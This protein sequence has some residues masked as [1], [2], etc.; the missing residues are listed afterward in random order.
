MK[1]IEFT[2]GIIISLL[3]FV[4]AVFAGTIERQVHY[5]LKE[6][7]AI[8]CDEYVASIKFQ[9]QSFA[10]IIEDTLSHKKTFVWNG[11]KKFSCD[12]ITCYYID[13]DS[14][15]KCIL[16]Y[17]QGKDHYLKVENK[18]YGPYEEINYPI[19]G[20]SEQ[21]PRNTWYL[22]HLFSKETMKTW[23]Y[24]N[25]FSYQ[26]MGHNFIYLDGIISSG[27]DIGEMRIDTLQATSGRTSQ[28]Y[29]FKSLNKT[30]AAKLTPTHISIDNVDYNLPLQPNDSVGR[31]E[32]YVFNDGSC[33][34]ELNVC[35]KRNLDESRELKVYISKGGMK[36][37][38]PDEAFNFKKQQIE[39]LKEIEE[40]TDY[41]SFFKNSF[42]HD[43][44]YKIIDPSERHYFISNINYPYVMID[45]QKFGKECAIYAWY[46]KTGNAFCWITLEGNQLVSY[47]YKI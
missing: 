35:N 14:Y 13:F 2:V 40:R 20:E 44:V 10:C 42:Y 22:W 16:I 46:D 25:S 6:N 31:S 17:T 8:F 26:Q 39:P 29:I 36:I 4:S 24:K 19:C 41:Q 3:F 7:E 37:L 27:Y 32:L 47:C 43:R 21:D 33:L 15:D 9:D 38:A 1:I 12:K 30:H 11:E 34:A 5:E 45:N 28:P 23:F 18:L